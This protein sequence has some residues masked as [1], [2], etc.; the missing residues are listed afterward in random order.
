MRI[1]AG[2]TPQL[3]DPGDILLRVPS[4]PA[5]NYTVKAKRKRRST[6]ALLLIDFINCLNFKDAEKLA[7][8]ALRAARVTA[9][10]K[11]RMNALGTPCIYANDNFRNWKSEF[12]A[13]VAKCARQPGP[14]GTIAELLRPGRDDLSILKPRHSAFY[15]TPLE[16]LL[17]ELEVSQLVVVGITVDMCVMATAQDAHVRKFSISVPANCVA[18]FTAGHEKTALATM[19]RTMHADTRAFRG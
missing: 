19:A 4:F 1:E 11:A 17:E 18:G 15:G 14:A 10:L 2:P 8:R 3:Q 7:P 13:L 5:P 6:K 9:R 12:S 16:F